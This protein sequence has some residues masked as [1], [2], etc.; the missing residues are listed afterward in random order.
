MLHLEGHLTGNSCEVLEGECRR[1]TGLGKR[2]LLDLSR[3]ILV[4]RHGTRLLISL[5]SDRVEAIH[6][7][8]LIAELI[9][10]AE[11]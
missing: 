4:D 1:W 11:G 8:P 6:V 10:D 9:L 2:V 5:R 3:L 7:P